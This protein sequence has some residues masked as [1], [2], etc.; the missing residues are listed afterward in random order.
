MYFRIFLPIK[1][2]VLRDKTM[3]FFKRNGHKD[4]KTVEIL[5]Q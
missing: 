5:F 2:S 1:I 4:L 3:P